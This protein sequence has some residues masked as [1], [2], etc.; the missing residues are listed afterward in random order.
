G[1]HVDAGVEGAASEL[2]VPVDEVRDDAEGRGAAGDRLRRDAGQPAGLQVH[3]QAA[4]GLVYAVPPQRAGV[5]PEVDPLLEGA[6]R[7]LRLGRSEGLRGLHRL[8]A[9]LDAD[10]GLA[11]L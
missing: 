9:G 6:D 10:H 1:G 2:R 11:W 7:G 8:A 3:G 5:L 4:G